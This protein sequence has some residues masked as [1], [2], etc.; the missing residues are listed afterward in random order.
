MVCCLVWACNSE[1]TVS[2]KP[3]N[4]MSYGIATSIM[5][6]DSAKVEQGLSGIIDEVTIKGKEGY[7]VEVQSSLSAFG[8]AKELKESLKSQ[9]Q[10]E[11]YFSKIIQEDETGFL[12][13]TVVDSSNVSYNF[14]KCKMLG[15]KELI[16]KLPSSITF[17]EEKA[18]WLF[19]HIWEKSN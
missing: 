5:A 3:L 12:Y 13:E 17:S 7:V 6:P 9:V 4:L 10:E 2:L 14:R 8:T 19:Q 15:E 18:N 11:S 1:P 16:F